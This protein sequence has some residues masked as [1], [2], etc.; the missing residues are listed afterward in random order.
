MQSSV[1]SDS[2]FGVCISVWPLW[3][4]YGAHTTWVALS[5]GAVGAGCCYKTI[6]IK[7]PQNKI[8]HFHSSRLSP[9]ICKQP[10]IYDH[11]P[12]EW[13]FYPVTMDTENN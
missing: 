9:L 8:P 11:I 5:T 4:Q 6:F 13:H 2:Y 10:V 1:D 7:Q 12:F 3:N